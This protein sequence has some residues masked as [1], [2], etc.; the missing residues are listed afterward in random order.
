MKHTVHFS[1]YHGLGNDFIM[2]DGFNQ[3]LEELP[4]QA[5]APK[6]CDRH[7]GIGA[8]GMI[9]SMPSD[10]SDAKMIIY[11]SDGS[12]PEICGNGIRCC[13]R[14]LHERNLVD[15]DVF[16]LE[17]SKSVVI[18]GLIRK[19]GTIAAIEVDMGAPNFNAHEFVSPTLPTTPQLDYQLKLPS[20]D[21]LNMAFVSMGNPHAVIYVEDVDTID[22]AAIGKEIEHHVLFANKTNVEFVQILSSNEIRI[23]VW[24][25]GAGETL[26]CGSGACAA[27]AVGI[28]QNTLDRAVHAHLPG[29]ELIINWH[30]QDDRIV[31]TGPAHHVYDGQFQLS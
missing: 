15:K 14:F 24:E 20:G 11:N 27:V 5:L 16:S 2:I 21:S 12:E 18:P 26:A 28:M 3:R 13:A 31:M 1:K 30:K 10:Q 6:L 29:G 22:V 25:R 17:L 23:R 7:F 9:L 19:D 8:D 4:L